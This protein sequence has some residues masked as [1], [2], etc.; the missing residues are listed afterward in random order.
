MDAIGRAVKASGGHVPSRA[1]V[2]DQLATTHFTGA[3]GSYSFDANGDATQQTVTIYS[4]SDTPVR[5]QL[6]KRVQ[7]PG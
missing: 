3:T 4:A 2:V 1:Q 7:F 5:W 6:L